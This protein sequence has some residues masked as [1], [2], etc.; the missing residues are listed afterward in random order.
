MKQLDAVFITARVEMKTKRTI[1]GSCLRKAVLT[2]EQCDLVCSHLRKNM[3]SFGYKIRVRYYKD[4]TI[5]WV[6]IGMAL[7]LRSL[8][9]QMRRFGRILERI[10]LAKTAEV[11]SPFPVS[12]Q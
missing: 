9:Q 1:I 11:C 10:G 8:G 2:P 3:G 4:T 5:F 6:E 7:G 12:Y